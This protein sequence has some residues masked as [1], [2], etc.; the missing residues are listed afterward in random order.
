MARP[1]NLVPTYRKHKQTARAAVS[2]YRADGLRTEILLPGAYGSDKSKQEYERILSQLRVNNGKLPADQ[3]TGKHDLTVA[4]LILKFLDE[5]V[6]PYYVDPVTRKP[7]REQGNFRVSLRPLKRLYGDM[8]VSDF[9]PQSLCTVRQAMIDGVWMTDAEKKEWMHA[10]RKR[11]LAR[12]ARHPPQNQPA[13]QDGRR[14]GTGPG[15]ARAIRL[16][17]A[18]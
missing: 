15:L 4:E 3:H 7:T 6:L 11:S 14:D 13:L 2:I 9:T 1:H 12:P 10:G 17:A 5:R 16:P 8:P 18:E